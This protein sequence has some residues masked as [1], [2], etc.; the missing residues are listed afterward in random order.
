MASSRSER[1][2]ARASLRRHARIERA[3]SRFVCA[4]QQVAAHVRQGIRL[5][6]VGPSP[7][8][9]DA[10]G[11]ATQGTPSPRSLQAAPAA[12]TAR[13]RAALPYQ[14]N[15][16]GET[17]RGARRAALPPKSRVVGAAAPSQMFVPA[18]PFVVAPRVRRLLFA[19]H[20][21]PGHAGLCQTPRLMWCRLPRTGCAGG[22]GLR[23]PGAGHPRHA[24]A[25]APRRRSSA[26]R[27]R[28]GSIADVR[29]P[30]LLCAH[31]KAA[32]PHPGGVLRSPAPSAPRS[33]SGREAVKPSR[34]SAPVLNTATRTAQRSPTGVDSVHGHNSL[35]P[36]P[37]PPRLHP[38]TASRRHPSATI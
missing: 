11:G 4:Q 26:A 3:R 35:T 13:R 16:D 37:C 28:T 2:L 19:G 20:E 17:C 31:A 27:G 14:S 32:D 38:G 24:A 30:P 21:R 5:R 25:W 8:R 1:C 7:W 34:S 9:P 22:G 23:F 33:L 36:E 18:N 12:R 29:M 10:M 6:H 15:H